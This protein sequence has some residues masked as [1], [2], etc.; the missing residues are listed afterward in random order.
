MTTILRTARRTLRRLANRAGFEITR[1]QNTLVARRMRLL[2]HYHVNL[3]F[4]VGANS[5][6]YAKEVRRFGYKGRIVSFEP[7]SG[8]YKDL[9]ANSRRDPLWETCNIALGSRDE[10]LEIN[11]SANTTSSSF[12]K[13]KPEHVEALSESKYTGKESVKIHRIDTII[14]DYYRPGDTLFLKMD[15]QGY[16]KHILDGAEASLNNIKRIQLEASLTTLYE[17]ETL[18]PQMLELMAE[19]GY[20]L[21]G[22]EPGFFNPETGRLLQVDCIFFRERNQAN[23]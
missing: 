5:G 21:M 8:I 17:G 11:I 9:V 7:L 20:M 18:L 16:E 13:M 2:S 19:K 23:D 3:I 1:R 4:D 6:Q 12:L 22:L 10:E 14:D 15:V